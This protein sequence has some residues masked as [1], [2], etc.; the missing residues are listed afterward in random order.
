MS[1]FLDF[2]KRAYDILVMNKKTK[3]PLG[4]IRYYEAWKKV[5]FEPKPNIVLSVGCLTEIIHIMRLNEG[6]L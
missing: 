2:R 3:V 4:N 1:N 6:K 5:V